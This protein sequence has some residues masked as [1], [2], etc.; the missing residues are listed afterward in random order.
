MDFVN[1]YD[2]NNDNIILHF[3]N[4]RSAKFN[5]IMLPDGKRGVDVDGTYLDT[6]KSFTGD[7]SMFQYVIQ[8]EKE[9]LIKGINND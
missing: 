5:I 8:K 4:G 2:I 3:K 1:G 9:K 7:F 6:G